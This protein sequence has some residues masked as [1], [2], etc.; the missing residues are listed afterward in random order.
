MGKESQI[1]KERNK[2][3]RAIIV[4]ALEETI[5]AQYE[6]HLSIKGVNELS[7]KVFTPRFPLK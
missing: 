6:R 4:H 2:E 7:E 5:R 3:S 1:A